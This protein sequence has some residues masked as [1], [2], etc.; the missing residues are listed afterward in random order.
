M[1]NR[2]K[3]TYNLPPQTVT[4]VRELVGQYGTGSQDAVVEL[5]IERLYRDARDLDDAARWA[6]AADDPDFR[7]EMGAIAT[8]YGDAD[9]WPR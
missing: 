3:R 6:D 2:T 8:D 5:A 7:T 9:P 1:S 4:Q